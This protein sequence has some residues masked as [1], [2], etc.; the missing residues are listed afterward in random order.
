MQDVEAGSAVLTR[1]NNPMALYIMHITRLEDKNVQF[2]KNKAKVYGN[3]ATDKP[4]S[5]AMKAWMVL[6]SDSRGRIACFFVSDPNQWASLIKQHHVR[7][8]LR[9]GEIALIWPISGGDH[10]FQGATI[11]TV[12]NSTVVRALADYNDDVD[13][14]QWL[15]GGG[16]GGGAEDGEQHAEM[17]R[18]VDLQMDDW[19]LCILKSVRACI[20]S[21]DI[22]AWQNCGGQ[23][24]GGKHRTA[25]PERNWVCKVCAE[26]TQLYTGYEYLLQI[27]RDGMEP[28]I[29]V[30]CGHIAMLMINSDWPTFESVDYP[31]FETYCHNV[32]TDEGILVDLTAWCKIGKMGEAAESDRWA[33]GE[34]VLHVIDIRPS[35]L[36]G[37]ETR[38]LMPIWSFKGRNALNVPFTPIAANLLG[39]MAQAPGRADQAANPRPKPANPL[40]PRQF[41][42]GW[43]VPQGIRNAGNTCG[44][45]TVL[46]FILCIPHL[47]ECTIAAGAQPPELRKIIQKLY[48]RGVE[49]TLSELAQLHTTVQRMYADPSD[50][51]LADATEMFNSHCQPGND[52]SSYSFSSTCT[53]MWC[54]N[55]KGVC[56]SWNCAAN[57]SPCRLC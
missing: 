41:T 10:V 34:A 50:H 36:A 47:T 20:I 11:L 15:G 45:G 31:T 51:R 17:Q 4:G 38:K 28:I 40:L 9:E 56:V 5:T 6:G 44:T 43:P 3:R 27:Q 25:K 8:G 54:Q 12:S 42:P 24:C 23:I 35:S 1:S 39:N 16:A 22:S 37:S 49:A 13:A 2:T 53:C 32:F 57:T 30:L 7:K 14:W 21:N 48:T 18:N 46:Q 19:Q 33:Y 52:G 55:V 29:A 26:S